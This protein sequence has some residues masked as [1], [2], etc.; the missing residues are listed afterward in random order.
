MKTIFST[1]CI[2]ALTLS[3]AAACAQT[4]TKEENIS[5]KKQMIIMISKI[6]DF[7]DKEKIKEN[8]I[9]DLVRILKDLLVL[10]K[11][12]PSRTALWALDESYKNNKIVYNHAIGAFS[13]EDQKKL[14]DLMKLL[15]ESIKRNGDN[16]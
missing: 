4:P 13:K 3:S 8:E 14:H 6:E 5:A 1:L 15:E 12:D 2:L 10:E 11:I 7:G 9:E 16:G